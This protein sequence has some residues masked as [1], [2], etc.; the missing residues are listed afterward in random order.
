MIIVQTI[1]DVLS[2]IVMIAT[3]DSYVMKSLMNVS[4]I[5]HVSTESALIILVALTLNAMK[6]SRDHCVVKVSMSVM[7]P[8]HVIMVL[9]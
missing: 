3:L 5:I 8:Y 6:D 4:V 2:V 7:K 9:V 1:I